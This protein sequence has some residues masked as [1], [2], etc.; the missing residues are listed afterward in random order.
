[1]TIRQPL[2][3]A[4]ILAGSATFSLGEDGVTTNTPDSPARTQPR[5]AGHW[6]RAMELERMLGYDADVRKLESGANFH[7]PASVSIALDAVLNPLAL[8]DAEVLIPRE[9]RPYVATGQFVW[10]DPNDETNYCVV[11]QHAGE[12][13]LW[14]A[15]AF[16]GLYETRIQL[17]RGRTREQD[18]LFIEWF[19]RQAA[20]EP[21]TAAFQRAAAA[22]EVP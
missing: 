3:I 14:H 1:M 10:D 11:T 2:V 9:Q 4:A 17:V 15:A 21:A 22:G 19:P 16:V 18:V 5:Y 6:V 12:T 8:G 13:Y 20:D 7:P